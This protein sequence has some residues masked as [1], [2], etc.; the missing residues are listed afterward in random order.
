MHCRSLEVFSSSAMHELYS[1]G[2]PAAVLAPLSFSFRSRSDKGPR[3]AEHGGSASGVVGSASE[4]PC[5]YPMG[6]QCEG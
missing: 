4:Q 3:L 5:P 6:R 2:N 1:G